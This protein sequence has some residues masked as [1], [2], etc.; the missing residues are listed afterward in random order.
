MCGKL[1]AGDARACVRGVGNQEYAGEPKRELALVGECRRLPAGAVSACAAWLGRT[2]NVTEN[3][4]F[5]REGCPRVAPSL[6]FACAWGA[7]RWQEPLVT[8]S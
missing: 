2:F 5:L 1:G 7:R 3:G 8:F 4:H 6:R